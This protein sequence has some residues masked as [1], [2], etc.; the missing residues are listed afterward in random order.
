M[1]FFYSKMF[2]AYMELEKHTQCVLV[3]LTAEDAVVLGPVRL[4]LNVRP[5]LYGRYGFIRS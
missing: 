1:K 2:Y 4:E 3:A 5:G